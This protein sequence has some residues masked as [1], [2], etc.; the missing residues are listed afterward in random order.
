MKFD[1]MQNKQYDKSYISNQE[2]TITQYKKLQSLYQ[3]NLEFLF[4][5][6]IEVI[7]RISKYQK[8]ELQENK[9]TIKVDRREIPMMEDHSEV[10]EKS[11]ISTSSLEYQF[12][13]FDK[14]LH[15]L[16]TIINEQKN[17]IEVAFKYYL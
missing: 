13:C 15:T 8:Q 14:Q 7:S 11:I 5:L 10:I 4:N 9:Q 3:T 16:Q 6:V 12:E 17:E 2:S 1:L